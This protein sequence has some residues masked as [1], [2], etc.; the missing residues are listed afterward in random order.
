MEKIKLNYL[1]L[2]SSQKLIA[3][4]II[5]LVEFTFGDA[6]YDNRK[7]KD[8]ASAKAVA[9]HAMQVYGGISIT[10]VAIIFNRSYYSARGA[11]DYVYRGLKNQLQYPLI[12]TAMELITRRFKGVVI[13]PYFKRIVEE[14]CRKVCSDNGIGLTENYVVKVTGHVWNEY[15]K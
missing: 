4:E 10:N 2:D 15:T 5:K 1:L 3:A 7:T 11:S 8:A 14:S 9:M 12:A 6:L 13:P